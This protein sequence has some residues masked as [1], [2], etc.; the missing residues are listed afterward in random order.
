MSKDKSSFASKDS[1]EVSQI[2]ERLMATD[3]VSRVL[4]LTDVL[5]Q[6][7]NILIIK[8]KDKWQ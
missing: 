8:N 1:V 4:G 2:I 6:D 5:S 3:I 7:A